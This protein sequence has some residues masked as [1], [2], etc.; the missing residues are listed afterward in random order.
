ME[1]KK[2]KLQKLLEEGEDWAKLEFIQGV[3]IVKMPAKGRIKAKL[4]F[5]INPVKEDG[6]VQKRKSLFILNSEQFN[7]FAKIFSDENLAKSIKLIDEVNGYEKQTSEK[8]SK[9]VG[10]F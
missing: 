9:V 10:K 3:Y 5:E 1:D 2:Q 8:D 4:A 7:S 6:S